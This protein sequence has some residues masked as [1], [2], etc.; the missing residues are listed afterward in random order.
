M[1][2]SSSSLSSSSSGRVVESLEGRTLLAAL[3]DVVDLGVTAAPAGSG[4]LDVDA[5]GFMLTPDGILKYRSNKLYPSRLAASGVTAVRAYP[6]RYSVQVTGSILSGGATEP[7]AVVFASAGGGDFN[8]REV[9]RLEPGG[10]SVANAMGAGLSVVGNARVAGGETHGFY[11]TWRN[12][13]YHIFDLND[14]RP[15]GLDFTFEDGVDVNASGQILATGRDGDGVEHSAVIRPTSGGTDGIE[16]AEPNG[17]ETG[18]RAADMNDFSRVVGSVVDADG[19]RQAALWRLTRNGASA[20]AVG[21]LGGGDSRFTRINNAGYAVGDATTATDRSHAFF[22]DPAVGR[23]QDL[24]ALVEPGGMTIRSAASIG[25]N[26]QIVGEATD[27]NGARHAVLLLPRDPMPALTPGVTNRG[28]NVR[29]NGTTGDDQIVIRANAK[30][31]RFLD[32]LFNGEL[33]QFD[34]STVTSAWVYGGPG[35]DRIEYGPTPRNSSGQLFGHSGND[36]IVIDPG[37]TYVTAAGD[38]GDDRIEG[39]TWGLGGRG[40]DTL[41]GTGLRD[42]LYGGLGNDSIEGNGGEADDLRGEAG[43]DTIVGGSGF[44]V[45]DAGAGDDSVVGARGQD[46]IRGGM[47]N[48]TVDAGAGDDEVYGGAGDDVLRGGEGND[49]MYGQAGDDTVWGQSGDDTIGG[50]DGLDRSWIALPTPGAGD[51]VLDGGTGN[52]YLVGSR[53]SLT[54]ADDNGKDTMTGGPGGDV[55]NARG[56]DVATDAGVDDIV[57][58]ARTAGAGPFAV[59]QTASISV[60]LPLVLGEG[61]VSTP[62]PDGMGKFAGSMFYADANGTLHMQDT[63]VREFTLGEFFRNWGVPVEAATRK[64]NVFGGLYHAYVAVNGVTPVS[65]DRFVVHAGDVITVS[66]AV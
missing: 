37:A 21:D 27:D 47:G 57:P 30:R 42:L 23:I 12:F 44:D 49:F 34:G 56:D 61:A 38:S 48:D 5:N 41:I 24:N 62:L 8:V 22:Y 43:D 18:V 36:Y 54:F 60:L 28:G 45:I 40:N 17:N 55:I 32:V 1:S 11:A 53:E 19:H 52:D 66:A 65:V 35:D 29:V 14:F 3:F 6:Y 26:G 20:V 51:D 13:S 58:A 15:A 31:P 50:D 46:S 7:R 39:A 2:R 63:V 33:T 25:D 59:Q 4:V 9:G 64:Q 16:L 10:P